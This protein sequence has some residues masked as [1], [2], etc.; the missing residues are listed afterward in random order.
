MTCGRGSSPDVSESGPRFKITPGFSIVSALCGAFAEPIA[1]MSFVLYSSSGLFCV[2]SERDFIGPNTTVS[3]NRPGMARLSRSES[4][5]GSSAGSPKYL[6]AGAPKSSSTVGFFSASSSSSDSSSSPWSVR[7]LSLLSDSSVLFDLSV[8]T[9]SLGSDSCISSFSPSV[10][11]TDSS[12]FESEYISSLSSAGTSS[13]LTSSASGSISSADSCAA[14]VSSGSA[15]ASVAAS[16]SGSVKYDS[17]ADSVSSGFAK[18]TSLT[19]SLFSTVCSAS[20]DSADSAGS[21]VSASA[22]ASGSS[23]GFSG[24]ASSGSGSSSG[25]DSGSF[26]S[27]Y[28]VSYSDDMSSSEYLFL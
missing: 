4:S 7:M 11:T 25:S 22:E 26:G 27:V 15:G 2:G 20:S 6:E 18:D 19:G 9:S 16:L 28:I 13:A 12:I 14:S 17:P 5:S 24:S 21:S 23:A 3:P 8:S 1:V 10:F